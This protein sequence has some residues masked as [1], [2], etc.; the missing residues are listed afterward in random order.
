MSSKQK[1]ILNLS[2]VGVD[3]FIFQD[4]ESTLRI[5]CRFCLFADRFY[6]RRAYEEDYVCSKLPYC[7]YKDWPEFQDFEAVVKEVTSLAQHD[8]YLDRLL[9]T[10]YH[11]VHG[12]YS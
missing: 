4:W 6:S 8:P 7:I 10:I 11:R 5:V 12:D 1:H 9:A 3:D 2:D